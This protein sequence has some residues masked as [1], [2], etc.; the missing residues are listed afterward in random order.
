MF[1]FYCI[2]LII[3]YLIAFKINWFPKNNQFGGCY[4]RVLM[5][6][7]TICFVLG[8]NGIFHFAQIV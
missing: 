8:K 1:D 4:S 7:N 3:R 6:G 5:K 2:C